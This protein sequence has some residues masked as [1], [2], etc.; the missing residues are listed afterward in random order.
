MVERAPPKRRKE[1]RNRRI[2]ITF[3]MREA[4]ICVYK[5]F[6]AKIHPQVFKVP[7][8]LHS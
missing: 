1:R 8:Q 4:Q 5:S 2:K 3:F 6:H 7:Y